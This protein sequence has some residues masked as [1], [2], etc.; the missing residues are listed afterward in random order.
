M[1]GALRRPSVEKLKDLF[2]YSS[3][4]NRAALSRIGLGTVVFVF[5]V[6]CL[7]APFLAP[8]SSNELVGFLLTLGGSLEVM[9][10]FRLL[11]ERHRRAGYF[12]GAM[13]VGM[14]ILVLGAPM[15]VASALVFFLAF[16]FLA[17]GI[18]QLYNIPGKKREGQSTLKAFLPVAGNFLM[19]GLLVFNPFYLSALALAGGL[20][21]LGTASIM[22][23]SPVLEATDAGEQI[24]EEL[25]LPDYDELRDLAIK[26]SE[27]QEALRGTDR[28][29]VAVYLIT[30]F[31]M[32]VARMPSEFSVVGLIGPF[33][34]VLGDAFVALVFTFGF[35]VPVYF[36]ARR[37]L[38]RPMRAAF[39][40][41]F[42][43][44]ADPVFWRKFLRGLLTL[45]L[46]FAIRMR[47][48]SYSLLIAVER[49]L[50]LG[51]P[52]AAV[53]AGTVP[54]WGMNW[55][56]DTENW[57][58]GVWDSYASHRTYAWRE[59]MVR[60]SVEND[61]TAFQGSGFSVTPD[62]GGED[63]SFIVIGDTG[64]GDASQL[65]LKDQILKCGNKPDVRF[66][67]ISSDV[68]YPDGAMR[69]YESR[70]FLPFKGFEEPIYAI[71]GNH[72]WYDALES[73]C[74]VFMEKEAARRAIRARVEED[75]N[76]S[77]T[78]DGRIDAMLEQAERLEDLY[79]LD[80]GHQRAPYFQ[81][82]TEKFALIAV[83][84]GIL[85]R[86]DPDQRRWLTSALREA[87]GKFV[88]LL[89]GHPF[90]AEGLDWTGGSEEFTD[91][92]NIA[93]QFK[94]NVVMAGDTHDFEYYRDPGPPEMHHF[95]NGGGGAFL[96]YGPAL[97]F[98]ARPALP[99]SAIYPTTEDVRT[100]IGTATPWYKLPL[101]WWTRDFNAWPF[102]AKWLS[103][104]FDYNTA[105]F[106]QSF[107]EVQVRPSEGVVRFIPWGV[108][109]PLKWSDLQRS[110]EFKTPGGEDEQ[111]VFEFPIL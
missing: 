73:F 38:R 77:T 54:I 70:F 52:I 72:D 16:G 97:A 31:A 101:W 41:A 25:D 4:F 15:L 27:E 35:L 66:L 47:Q 57:A 68:I 78:T 71:P 1:D 44:G 92:R 61:G 75:Q 91:L 63:F 84:T 34:A 28:R 53:I 32:H 111:A 40:L 9:H 50:A 46:S 55:Y 17:D 11:G 81:L 79:N 56:F 76:L 64:E 24:T 89:L 98:P 12:A 60:A 8:A 3:K 102:S 58:S 109:G 88:M 29:W 110:E 23:T 36:L 13:T 65:V 18:Q 100:K 21:L 2:P 62:L 33:V 105:P 14:G 86:V 49:G 59:A 45:R 83:D 94:V 74:A 10:S 93:G 108:H 20:R 51:L 106:H 104:A 107:V 6:I 26:I 22:L 42:S 39:H 82:Q 95:V 99:E 48:A 30:L 43:P 69:D 96:S 90:Y 19:A 103:A 37:L 85:R 80:V 87:E 7:A 5:A 67:V